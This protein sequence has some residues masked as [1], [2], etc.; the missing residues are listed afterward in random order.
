VGRMNA[1]VLRTAGDPNVLAVADEFE[2]RRRGVGGFGFIGTCCCVVVI[3]IIVGIVLL[4][5]RRR[6]PGPP[7]PGQ[8]PPS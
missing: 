1:L 6:R 2:R 7:P 8:Y 3:L 5:Q 4:V